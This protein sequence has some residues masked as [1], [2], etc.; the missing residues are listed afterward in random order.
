VAGL[1]VLNTAVLQIRE[2][3][4][5]LG[6]FKAIGMTP[7]QTLAMVVSSAAGIG[8]FAGLIAIPAGVA[9]HRYLVPVM[10]HAGG[11]NVPGTLL[12]VYTPGELV[13]LAL[14]GLVIAAGG[15]LGP[16]TWVARTRTTTALRAE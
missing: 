3:A 10:G 4:H 15:A 14:G 5:D 7:R 2:H 9:L 6:V 11:T 16:A 13:L 1:G 12:S 8:A